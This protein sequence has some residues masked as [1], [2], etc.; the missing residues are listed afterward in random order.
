[1]KKSFPF[2][3]KVFPNGRE[4]KEFYRRRGY[5]SWGNGRCTLELFLWFKEGDP[6]AGEKMVLDWYTD[7]RLED[8]L[9]LTGL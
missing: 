8:M 4:Y 7:H 2:M 6:E 5:E 3:S 1:M 9:N